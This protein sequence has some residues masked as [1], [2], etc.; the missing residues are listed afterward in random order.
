MTV[1]QSITDA[2]HAIRN[3]QAF[4][5]VYAYTE[6]AAFCIRLKSFLFCKSSLPSLSFFSFRIHYMDFPY[7]LL[8]LLSISVFL[9][10]SFSVFTLFLVVGSVR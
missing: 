5:K 7:C 6:V 3:E 8:L 2:L 1:I 10:F 4:D 9:H